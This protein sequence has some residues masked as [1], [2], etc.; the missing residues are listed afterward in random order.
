MAHSSIGTHGRLTDLIRGGLQG[1]AEIIATPDARFADDPVGWMDTRL[2]VHLWSKQ[3][4]VAESVR[5]HRRTAVH[6]CHSSGKSFLAARLVCWWLETTEPGEAYV[7]TSAPT[8]PQVKAILWREITRAHAKASLRGRTNQKE[9]Y[10]PTGMASEELVAFG[11]KPGDLDE[12]AFQGIHARRVLVV[13]DEAAGISSTLFDAAGGLMAN[14]ECRLLVMGNPDFS[15]SRFREVCRPGSDWN[16]IHI[17][18]H[19]TPNFTGESIP[20]HLTHLLI[21]QRYVDEVAQDHGESSARYQSRVGGEFPTADED[22][23]IPESWIQQ[24]L[25]RTLTPGEPN[26]LGVDVGGGGDRNVI[27]QRRG[28][29]VRILSRDQEPNTMA[30]AGR[31]IQALRETGAS[32]AKIDTIGIGRGVVDRGREGGHAFEPVNVSERATNSERFANLRSELWW[33]MRERFAQ[34]DLDLDPKATA[35]ARQFVGIKYTTTS[36]GQILVEKKDDMKRRFGHSP[37]DADAVVLAF[38]PPRK[39]LESWGGYDPDEPDM[40]L[41]DRVREQGSVF[42]GEE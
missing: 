41:E 20:D 32:V 37:D 18:A 36:R 19:D 39:P 9:W 30:T 31:V 38:K 4:Q 2:G 14:N 34:G 22:T 10:L 12:E 11:R 7:V 1:A 6:S 29:V 16:V 17:G 13:L 33:M 24:A 15:G 21:G 28:G 5:D 27:A 35:L 42:P 8:E 26:E 40:A 3:R 23:L 25:D